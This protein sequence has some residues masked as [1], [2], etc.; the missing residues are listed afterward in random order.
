MKEYFN[1]DFDLIKVAFEIIYMGKKL[2]YKCIY[3]K[4]FLL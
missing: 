4:K 1:F 3:N 2:E